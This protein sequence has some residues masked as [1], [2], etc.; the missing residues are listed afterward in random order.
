MIRFPCYVK[1]TID[2]QVATLNNALSF[3]AMDIIMGT[4]WCKILT[5][6]LLGGAAF[7]A[8]GEPGITDTTILIGQTVGLTGTV[9]TPVR[10]MNEGVHAYFSQ[11]NKQGGV[12]GRKI[13][14]RV[15]DDKFDPALTL[16]NAE[17]LI[18][19]ERVLS[20]IHI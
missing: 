15:L 1:P 3:S 8:S 11:I 10:E 13:E 12:H 5:A 6:L 18:K 9:S 7:S 14:M 2:V 16:A 4:T 20:L 19:K 17:T